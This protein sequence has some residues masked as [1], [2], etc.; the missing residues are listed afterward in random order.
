VWVAGNRVV[1]GRQVTTVDVGTA[2]TEV[3]ARG[4]RLAA[5]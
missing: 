3:D 5:G 1:E 4:R 2:M